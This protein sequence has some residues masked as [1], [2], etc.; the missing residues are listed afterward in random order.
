MR[1][2]LTRDLVIIATAKMRLP[3]RLNQPRSGPLDHTPQP[4][5]HL[6]H[7]VSAPDPTRA[8]PIVLAGFRLHCRRPR[9]RQLCRDCKFGRTDRGFSLNDIASDKWALIRPDRR[10]GQVRLR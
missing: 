7:E 2:F 6:L 10:E 4:V 9:V 1:Q 5:A 8:Y 3:E